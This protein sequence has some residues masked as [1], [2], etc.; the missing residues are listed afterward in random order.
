MRVLALH[1]LVGV[2]LDGPAIQKVIS[3]SSP[4]PTAASVQKR[5]EPSEHLRVFVNDSLKPPIAYIVELVRIG[6]KDEP[7]FRE[8]TTLIDEKKRSPGARASVLHVRS[9]K[10]GVIRIMV[11]RQQSEEQEQ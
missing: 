9:K 6:E 1:T 3:S 8:T 11:T 7:F 2:A 4:V 5:P 10:L